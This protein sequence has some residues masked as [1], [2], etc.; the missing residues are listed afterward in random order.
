MPLAEKHC[1]RLLYTANTALLC[2]PVCRRHSTGLLHFVKQC[3]RPACSTYPHEV[4]ALSVQHP[5]VLVTEASG[6]V[7]VWEQRLGLTQ[8][9]L[10]GS[11]SSSN[12]DVSC[13]S[14][15]LAAQP[16]LGNPPAES[17]KKQRPCSEIL[18]HVDVWPAQR[19]PACKAYH[20]SP[21]GCSPRPA[22][23]CP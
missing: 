20:S 11:G 17:A 23:S 15:E 2:R 9:H 21:F 16:A 5:L 18:S 10:S 7:R 6:R 12:H 4:D 22:A 14:L 3:C 8:E 19:L 13:Q 1:L